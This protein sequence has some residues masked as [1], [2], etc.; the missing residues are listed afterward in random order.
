VSR[1]VDDEEES[2]LLLRTILIGQGGHIEVVIFFAADIPYG[3]K[4]VK[5]FLY[6]T[7]IVAIVVVWN[8]IADT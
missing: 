3:R 8:I 4:L 2:I 1:L 7:I 5:A 6:G